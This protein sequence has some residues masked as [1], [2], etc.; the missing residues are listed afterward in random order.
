MDNK[1]KVKDL[2]LIA[3]FAV[4]YYMVMLIIGMMGLVPIL[5]LAF[6]AV[7]ALVQGV[8]VMLFMAKVPKPWALFIFGMMPVIVSIATGHTYVVVIHSI[9]FV[10]IAEI[11]FRKGNFKSFKYNAL[12]HSF[13]SCAII[14]SVMQILLVH[15]QLMEN[16]SNMFPKEYIETLERLVTIP[17]MLIL[18]IATFIM[19]LI[20]AYIGKK[21]L[22]KHFEKAGIV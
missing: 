9:I 6:Y 15:D 5:Y 2:V 21:M 11:L 17:N 7:N 18:Y 16:F 20:G 10:G 12:A 19:G 14:G 22:R 3:V 13:L 1:L 8:V 4:I